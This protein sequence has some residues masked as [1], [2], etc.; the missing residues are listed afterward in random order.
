MKRQSEP[1]DYTNA[2]RKMTRTNENNNSNSSDCNAQTSHSIKHDQR[3]HIA[4]GIVGSTSSGGNVRT[5]FRSHLGSKT[6]K[7]VLSDTAREHQANISSNARNFGDH[8][9]G[10]VFLILSLC[11]HTAHSEHLR[12]LLQHGNPE[13]QSQ[14]EDFPEPFC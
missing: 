6:L 12:K 7:S 8:R 11:N 13:S 2:V 5:A 14:F 9:R 4:H 1:I 10:Q 3:I